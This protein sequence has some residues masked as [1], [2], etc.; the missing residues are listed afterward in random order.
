MKVYFTEEFPNEHPTI[1]I[2]MSTQVQ[3]LQQIENIVINNE[4]GKVDIMDW[5]PRM[6]VLDLFMN[7]REEFNIYNIESPQK[8]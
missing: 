2:D 7:M 5:N 3:N 6:S 4:T 8:S 1:H